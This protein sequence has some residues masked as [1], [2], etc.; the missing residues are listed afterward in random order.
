MDIDTKIR[1]LAEVLYLPV[2]RLHGSEEEWNITYTH[3]QLPFLQTLADNIPK[4]HRSE[5]QINAVIRIFNELLF[6]GFVR[7]D[8]NSIFLIGPVLEV[9][10]DNTVIQ[11][12]LK[13]LGLPVSQ[14][15][16]FIEYYESTP[17]HSIYKFTQIVAYMCNLIH[18]ENALTALDVLPEGYRHEIKDEPKQTSKVIAADEHLQQIVKSQEYEYKLYSY[19]YTGQYEQ[20]KEFISTK[21]YGGETGVLSKSAFRQ[22]KYLVITSIAL[23][24]RAAARGGLNYNIAMQQ[25]DLYF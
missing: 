12:V 4:F 7:I 24:S 9:P 3:P 18:E 17:R 2:T 25:A 20:L 11:F 16:E 6:Y 22:N 10:I 15:D 5:Q 1:K 21:S 13:S 19:V 14:M 23:A 8:E